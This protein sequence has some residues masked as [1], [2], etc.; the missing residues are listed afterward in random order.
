MDSE[1]TKKMGGF[2]Q[3]MYLKMMK[4]WLTIWKTMTIFQNNEIAIMLMREYDFKKSNEKI[5]ILILT[6]ENGL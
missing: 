3:K 4:L 1:S 5:R 2:R 6:G